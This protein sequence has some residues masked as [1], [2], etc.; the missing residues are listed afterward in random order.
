M[1]IL[2]PGS[3]CVNLQ[4]QATNL[5]RPTNLASLE[6][7]F[8]H[9]NIFLPSQNSYLISGQVHSYYNKL[10]PSYFGDYFIPISSIHSYP[11]RCSIQMFVSH[12]H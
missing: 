1:N 4:N 6:E 7:S 8:K 3:Q 9:L 2:Y 5:V 10:L 12:K 11:T